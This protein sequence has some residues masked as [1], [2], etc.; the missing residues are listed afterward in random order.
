[1]AQSTDRETW[2]TE[3]AVRSLSERLQDPASLVGRRREALERFRVLPLEPNP[4]YQKYGYFSGVDLAGLDLV[5]TGPELPRP[6]VGDRTVQVI[7]DAAGS[8]ITLSPELQEAGVSVR[9][10]RALWADGGDA[11]LR[12]SGHSAGFTDRL[13][14]LGAATLNRG[15]SLDLPAKLKF[16]VRLQD[17]SVLSRP[18][19]ALSVH[20][21]I[22]VGAGSSLLATEEL[23]STATPVDGQ[24]LYASSTNV[25]V[26][27]DGRADFLGVHAPDSKAISVYTRS[28]AVG[29]RG[30]LT[31]MW[32]GFDGFRTKLRTHTRLPG[33][34][35][36]AEDL[37][38]FLGSGGASYDSSVQITH[39]GT[40]TYGQSITRGVFR[41]ESRGMSRGLVRIEHEARKT[42][43]FLSEHAMLLSRGARS[44][45]IPVLEI[46][47]RDVKA[48]HSSSVAPVDP[49]K[50]FYLESR[51]IPLD[52]SIRMI[53][54]GFLSHV[55]ERSPIPQLREAL[56]P[57]L[58]ARW[59][60]RPISWA[61][62]ALP[63]LP[64]LQ[65][66]GADATTDWRFDAKLR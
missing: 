62:E 2:V 64:A 13:T 49:E 10:L 61:A 25:D 14:A 47:C 30:R 22:A 54:E 51:G 31:W 27:P 6:V 46:L 56:Y 36:H 20:R 7:H 53:G 26:G 9:D 65:S 37:Q 44:D 45:T 34:G 40:D 16:P 59:E 48:T 35:S 33:N 4:L 23:F 28:G 11:A 42:L 17:I 55:L 32:N 8:H 39:I 41:D 60:G 43:S 1:M 38:T 52:A 15:Y 50:I 21:Q 12:F 18:R 24:R 5:A 29:D 3:D 63:S 19:E 57:H 66:S 58:A